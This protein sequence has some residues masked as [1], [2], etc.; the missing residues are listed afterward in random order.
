MDEFEFEP[1]R[2]ST[3]PQETLVV[4][5]VRPHTTAIV[6]TKDG[7]YD[8]V[9]DARALMFYLSSGLDP[10]TFQTFCG[11]I[12]TL[13][14]NNESSRPSSRSNES[15]PKMRRMPNWVAA[16]RAEE[17]SDDETFEAD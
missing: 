17:E 2:V 3:A 7:H 14:M 16:K 8:P 11:M 13:Y 9:R 1:E 6:L 5:G 12:A 15:E 10:V 4:F